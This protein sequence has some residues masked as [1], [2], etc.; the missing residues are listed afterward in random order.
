VIGIG[1]ATH[2]SH[3]DQAFKAELIKQLVTSGK[4]NVLL[5]EANRD[6]GEQFDRYVREGVG[7]PAEVLRTGSFFRIW[8]NDEFAGLLLW[9]RNWNRTAVSKVRIIAIDCQDAGSDA[10]AALEL[11][12]AHDPQAA[13]QLRAGLGSL[14]PDARFVTW[15]HQ[16]DRSAYDTAMASS[17]TLAAWFETA[18]EAARA[19]PGFARARRAAIMV[20]QAFLAF[21]FE[22]D[23]ADKSQLDAAYFARR[24]RFMGAN[25]VAM[26]AEDERA[27]LWAHDLHV[28]EDLPPFVRALG[29]VTLGT[30]I[31]DQLG[32]DYASVGFT[33]SR[34]S[35]RTNIAAD[36]QASRK[37]TDKSE[38]E[39]VTLPNDR[40]GELG[41]LFDRTGAQAMWIDLATRPDTPLIQT[42]SRRPYWRGWAGARI[43]PSLWQVAYPEAGDIPIDP[44]TGHDVIVWFQSISP[45]RIWP[46]NSPG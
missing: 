45:S 35:F 44:V 12:A 18:P 22:R 10:A 40:T 5:L 37:P 2:G 21:E 15:L 11:I 13:A 43:V 29:F 30:V 46:I 6:A 36:D 34:G 26:L 8:K 33:W 4:V 38:L 14:I 42:W 23:D 25:A 1:E 19:D 16:V 31:R 17:A 32:E 3:Q 9:L 27:A 41:N 7:D 24:D 28:L 20:R 39:V